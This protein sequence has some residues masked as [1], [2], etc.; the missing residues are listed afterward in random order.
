MVHI[1]ELK[2]KAAAF[3]LPEI[4]ENIAHGDMPGDQV[5]IGDFRQHKRCRFL[6]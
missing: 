2:Q 3:V 5:Q 4:P 1:E 6:F